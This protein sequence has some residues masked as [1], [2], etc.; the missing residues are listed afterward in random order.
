MDKSV[1]DY[2]AAIAPDQR[3]L[4]DRLHRLVLEANPKIVITF[5]YKM[6]TYEVGRRRLH[7]AAWKHWVSIYG[8]GEDR[9]AGFTARHPELKTVKGTIQLRPKDADKV[10]DRELR[11]MARAALEA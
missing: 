2:I 1:R 7:I 9:D 6:P 8:V 5:A 10:S 4:F 3:P 11:E